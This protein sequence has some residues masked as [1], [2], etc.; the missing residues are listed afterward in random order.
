LL[1]RQAVHVMGKDQMF[2]NAKARAA[3]GWEPRV[4]YA[5]G[6]QRTVEWLREERGLAG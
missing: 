1:S 2:S 5:T 3:L 6:L 4:D